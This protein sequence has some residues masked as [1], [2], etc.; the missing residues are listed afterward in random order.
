MARRLEEAVEAAGEQDYCARIIASDASSSYPAEVTRG[1]RRLVGGE[2]EGEAG[3]GGGGRDDGENEADLELGLSLGATKA[4]AAV[5]SHPGGGGGGGSGEAVPWRDYCRILTAKDFPSIVVSRGSPI[6]SSSSSASSPNLGGGG[7]VGAAGVSGTKRAADSASPPGKYLPASSQVVGWPPVRAYRINTLM[8]NSKN[9]SDD[10]GSK[11]DR[12]K[13]ASADA[14]AAVAAAH[15]SAVK[16]NP[17]GKDQAKNGPPHGGSRFVKVKMDGMPIGRKVDLS[18]H[19]DYKTLALALEDMFEEHCSLSGRRTLKLLDGASDF[20]LT[21]E[22]KDGDWL[23][24]GD[25]PWGMFVSSIKRLRI[26]RTSDAR[27]L[28]EMPACRPAQ[29]GLR[30]SAR[31]RRGRSRVRSQFRRLKTPLA[32]KMLL[33]RLAAAPP[34]AG[35]RRG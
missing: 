23:L 15:H 3:W 31:Q 9:N 33:C 22:D 5:P 13:K 21:Y 35:N 28:R 25:V 16:Q 6:S 8:N 29:L 2:N 20:V 24:V 26:M 4:A 11:D 32:G 17:T 30:R 18:S 10:G 14:V 12:R 34:V 1:A 19:C 7:R 27:G